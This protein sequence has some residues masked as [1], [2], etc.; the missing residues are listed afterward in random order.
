[1]ELLLS[2]F[3]CRIHWFFCVLPP[4]YLRYHIQRLSAI[5]MS[6]CPKTHRNG[7]CR[8]AQ[9]ILKRQ[10]GYCVQLPSAGWTKLT[11]YI[12]NPH[13]PLLSQSFPNDANLLLHAASVRQL[14]TTDI[15]TSKPLFPPLVVPA[16]HLSYRV[17]PLS[18]SLT[19][20]THCE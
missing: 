20:A 12:S 1:M 16:R 6:K 7:S 8:S 15:H 9:A 18:A 10:S 19:C 13:F 11:L 2:R 4:K 14:H 5:L 17:R 3:R